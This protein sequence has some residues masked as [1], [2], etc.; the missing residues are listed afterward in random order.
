[1]FSKFLSSTPLLKEF[2]GSQFFM[3]IQD[4]FF[5]VNNSINLGDWIMVERKY[6]YC[7]PIG[8]VI[9]KYLRLREIWWGCHMWNI[10]LTFPPPSFFVTKKCFLINQNQFCWLSRIPHGKI[11]IIMWKMIQIQMS[12]KTK[13][14]LPTH[15]WALFFQSILLF[16]SSRLRGQNTLV[17]Y[18]NN[19]CSV[20]NEPSSI[21]LK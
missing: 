20:R 12:E 5:F 7:F 10:Q 1:M 2:F 19:I 3:A 9:S 11:F 13:A 4:S 14:H 15:H 6:F 18:W 17:V 8:S 16:F 21:N